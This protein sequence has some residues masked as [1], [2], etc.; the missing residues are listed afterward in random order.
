MAVAPSPASTAPRTASLDGSSRATRNGA[1][2][3][4][5]VCHRGFEGRTG[6]RAGLAQHPFGLAEAVGRDGPG[7]SPG[8]AGRHDDDELVARH[9]AADE[10]RVVMGTLDEAEIGRALAHG[11]RYLRGV[12]DRQADV[13]AGMAPSERH[14]MARQP[15]ARDRLARRHRQGSAPQAAEFGQRQLGGR[16]PCQHG[17][18]LD[19]EH[20]T[21]LRQNDT[22]ADAVEQLRAMLALER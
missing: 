5:E 17:P 21:G 8:V 6:A 10:K 13:D 22:A 3:G 19:Q 18:G 4:R 9:D 16:S 14:E 15:V 2:A 1:G 12:A 20:L 7:D 11:G